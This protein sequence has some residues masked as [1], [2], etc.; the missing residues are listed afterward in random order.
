MVPVIASR[1]SVPA[2][3]PPRSSYNT[4]GGCTARLE[5][6][7]ELS[8]SRDGPVYAT[9]SRDP[10]LM[11]TDASPFF[12]DADGTK[13]PA[14]QVTLT[15]LLP[16]QRRSDI[17]PALQE[18]VDVQYW[19][20]HQR[21]TQPTYDIAP[22]LHERLLLSVFRFLCFTD[23]FVA[24]DAHEDKFVRKTSEVLLCGQVLDYRKTS[25]L[26]LVD[27][28][29]LVLEP[30]CS[31][32]CIVVIR[33]YAR[34]PRR[35]VALP[36]DDVRRQT[37][38]RDEFVLDYYHDAPAA[39]RPSPFSTAWQVF[40]AAEVTDPADV[41]QALDRA[42]TS[43]VPA[44]YAWQVVAP[45]EFD[46]FAP[47]DM[48]TLHARDDDWLPLITPA[49][50][51]LTP[52]TVFSA[53]LTTGAAQAP[54]SMPA[55]SCASSMN[56]ILQTLFQE[57]Q[58]LRPARSNPTTD[59]VLP[60]DLYRPRAM[61]SS[62]LLIVGILI[63]ARF[64]DVD[65][66]ALVRDFRMVDVISVVYVQGQA[67]RALRAQGAFCSGLAPAVRLLGL[68]DTVV[69]P[70]LRD[71]DPDLGLAAPG[72]DEYFFRFSHM[73]WH[74]RVC[75]IHRQESFRGRY[76]VTKP[77]TKMLFSVDFFSRPFYHFLS[78]EHTVGYRQD[79]TVVHDDS[80]WGGSEPAPTL[81]IR[82]ADQFHQV[83]HTIQEAV[84]LSYPFDLAAV[85]RLV[86]GDAT[87]NVAVSGPAPLVKAM[88]NVYQAVFSNLFED[89][90]NGVP[91][92]GLGRRTY[93]SDTRVI[94]TAGPKTSEVGL[95]GA[96]A[97]IVNAPT[98]DG[99]MAALSLPTVSPSASDAGSLRLG[100]SGV[101]V[102]SSDVVMAAQ[103]VP[104]M[105]PSASDAG[106]PSSG[107]PGVP[108]VT[109]DTA[110]T[111]DIEQIATPP[112]LEVRS[113]CSRAPGAVVIASFDGA[114]RTS[115]RRSAYAW[116]VWSSS[117][118]LVR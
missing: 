73:S 25:K 6:P 69:V 83:L 56:E 111:D 49:D 4:L 30:V 78:S 33:G 29:D 19:V 93:L 39:S 70:V 15:F 82:R 98:F 109:S 47:Q 14:W 97:L 34:D 101:P 3:S 20:P 74:D 7:D 108:V 48:S 57:G 45:R 102:T 87:Q 24:S 110:I 76:R 26:S 64:V 27:D 89:I 40:K 60:S 61:S 100:T 72:T 115:T 71:T 63:C 10:R 85:F 106:S 37:I 53:T 16:L 32:I 18:H 28:I 54:G 88:C 96:I 13:R 44:D 52:H 86:H 9:L 75:T 22:E 36:L 114:S 42:K 43:V 51:S 67:V 77:T 59:N 62:R 95:C 116:C 105:S 118:T 41:R 79:R 107:T 1:R 46:E 90:L 68:G 117:K 84:A 11:E 92:S 31:Y 2:R 21:L 65:V 23:F 12:D 66:T 80:L 94:S 112:A 81:Q 38:S 35:V 8:G 55:T 50:T 58:V 99:I 17:E 104:T 5:V 113:P 91:L 103:N